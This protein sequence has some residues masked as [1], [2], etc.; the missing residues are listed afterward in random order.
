M[1]VRFSSWI[2]G[3]W[4]FVLL[5]RRFI[6]GRH[7]LHEGLGR[8]SVEEVDRLARLTTTVGRGKLAREVRQQVDIGLVDLARSKDTWNH[9]AD[10]GLG[11]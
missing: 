1:V 8:T 3:I 5:V 4:I 11:V 9:N 2:R 7:V 10:I 6:V